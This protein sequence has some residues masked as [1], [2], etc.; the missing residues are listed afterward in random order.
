[1]ESAVHVSPDERQLGAVD[2]FGSAHGGHKHVSHACDDD[3]DDGATVDT[4]YDSE[5]ERGAQGGT[6]GRGAVDEHA[7][8]RGTAEAGGKGG[9]KGA[10][11]TEQEG[12]GGDVFKPVDDESAVSQ[13][14]F[15]LPSVQLPTDIVRDSVRVLV[16]QNRR[17]FVLYLRLPTIRA[18]INIA[19][20][21]HMLPRVIQD[22]RECSVQT[23]QL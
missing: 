14:S 4:S 23:I 21:V 15:E 6:Q 20:G 11:H 16:R 1:M 8:E 22:R 17:E 18:F 2:A 3:E 13:W 10:S 9:S 12:Q 7:Q 19:D 5:P